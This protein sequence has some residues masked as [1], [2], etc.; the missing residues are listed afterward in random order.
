[1]Q[2]EK[3]S[4]SQAR[5]DLLIATPGRLLDHLGNGGLAPQLGALKVLVLDE[6]DRMLDVSLPT[7]NARAVYRLVSGS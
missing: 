5:A 4:L 7:D 2:S 6:A 3:R 1:M